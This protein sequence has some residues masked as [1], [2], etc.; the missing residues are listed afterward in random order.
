MAATQQKRK[1]DETEKDMAT[2]ATVD[3]PKWTIVFVDAR[4]THGGVLDVYDVPLEFFPEG[5]R[6]IEEI[7]AK[8]LLAIFTKMVQRNSVCHTPGDTSVIQFTENEA[9]YMQ[10]L[11]FGKVQMPLHDG[12]D[13]DWLGKMGL[14]NLKKDTSAM[15]EA[16][17][18]KMKWD[19]LLT[20][21]N[22]IGRGIF[23]RLARSGYQ[24]LHVIVLE[25]SDNTRTSTMF[26]KP[27]TVE[28]NHFAF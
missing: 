26:G 17:C 27:K 16:C 11:L 4:M 14:P 9:A 8:G 7:D 10:Q 13:L 18:T 3:D 25:S 12:P 20:S 15:C 22:R 6:T 24:L 21:R 2:V 5:L 28:S 19:G 1:A 23:G